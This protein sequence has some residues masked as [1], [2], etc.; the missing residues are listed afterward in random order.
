MG[1]DHDHGHSHSNSGHSHEHDSHGH[2]YQNAHDDNNH[3]HGHSH[4]HGANEDAG[5]NHGHSHIDGDGQGKKKRTASDEEHDDNQRRLKHA[6]IFVSVFMVIEVIGGVMAHSIAIMTDAAHL[7]TDIS[8]FVMAIIAAKL[9]RTPATKHLSYGLVRAEVLSAL[10]S[11]LLIW[12]L[13]G[14]LV[15]EAIG[16]ICDWFLGTA[17]PVDGKLMTGVAVMGLA[18]NVV[19]LAILGFGHGHGEGEGEEEG[20]DHGHSHEHGHGHSHFAAAAAAPKKLESLHPKVSDLVQYLYSEATNQ[21]TSQVNCEITA[22]G[23]ETPLGILSIEQVEQGEDVLGQLHEELKKK[24]PRGAVLQQLSGNFYTAIPHNIGRSRTDISSAVI[25]D[26]GELAA[27]QELCQLMRDMLQVNSRGENVLFYTDRTAEQ[28]EALGCSIDYVPPNSKEFKDMVKEMVESQKRSHGTIRTDAQK[29]TGLYKVRREEEEQR[30]TKTIDNQVHLYHGSRP[31]N[32]VGLLSRGILLPKVV[33]SMGINRTDG[34]WLGDGIYFGNADTAFGYA[35]I[36]RRQTRLMLINK[37]ALG[38]M[39]DYSKITYG[40][41]QPK[42]GFNSC[43]G[44]A[45]TQF[46]DDEYVV[47]DERQQKIQYLVE[48]R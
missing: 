28:Y 11:T 17:E 15:W 27:K 25:R 12:L 30:F 14:A 33:V 18:V 48:T 9:A 31:S 3:S 41:K 23:I 19:L 20:G 21:L 10:A 36:G 32:F 22:N 29:I 34:G 1:H 46:Y 8:S 38:K 4:A 26:L 45:G 7:L 35:H 47:Y 37:V 6:M 2:S 16:R 5:H 13:T 40:I 24:K 43:H 39:Q 42:T 44:V